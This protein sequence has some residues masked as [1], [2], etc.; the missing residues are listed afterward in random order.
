MDIDEVPKEP[1]RRPISSLHLLNPISSKTLVQHISR[2]TPPD[3][4]PHAVINVC[5]S[6]L[7]RGVVGPCARIYR[8]PSPTS[9]MPPST[10]VEVPATLNSQGSLFS[11]PHGLRNQWLSRVPSP[12]ARHNKS[13][14]PSTNNTVTRMCAA[15]AEPHRKQRLGQELLAPPKSTDLSAP[16]PCSTDINGQHPVVPDPEDL[17]GFVTTGEF[18]LS[19]GQSMAI[20]T[21]AV[22]KVLSDVRTDGKEGRL[23]IVRNAGENVGWIAKWEAI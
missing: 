12:N 13:S 2:E 6:L 14:P 17:I 1:K 22:E 4:P 3:L 19:E 23:C 20:G 11:L 21:I 9:P 10:D 7:T 18:S 15:S 8:L 16:N 5:I